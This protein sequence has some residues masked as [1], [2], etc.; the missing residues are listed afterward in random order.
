M[1]FKHATHK[2]VGEQLTFPIRR[3]RERHFHP[4][5]RHRRVDFYA[6]FFLPSFDSTRPLGLLYPTFAT[7][8]TTGVHTVV[9]VLGPPDRISLNEN[10]RS[11]CHA[12]MG[13]LVESSTRFQSSSE[14]STQSV[15]F[16]RFC[17]TIIIYIYKIVFTNQKCWCII[18]I[19]R[20]QCLRF[21]LIIIA[22]VYVTDK[23]E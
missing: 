14:M 13:W 19:I 15:Y 23:I 20:T 22:Y 6:A 21:P 8:L 2:Y 3:K 10:V 9:V 18:Y 4:R 11:S 17:R 1:N 7:P 12:S 5:T 16:S